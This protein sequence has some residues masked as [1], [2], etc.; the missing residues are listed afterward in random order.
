[1]S[2]TFFEALSA[3]GPHPSLGPDAE[4]YGQF[5]GSWTGEV[6]DYL[7]DGT[8]NVGSVEIHFRWVLEGRRHGNQV[9]QLGT[10]DG[11][12]IRWTFSKSHCRLVPLAGSRARSRRWLLAAGGGV[13]RGAHGVILEFPG[14]ANRR[15][16]SRL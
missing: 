16:G 10:R 7:Q 15:S 13:L 3:P 6:R 4:T 14:R 8:R 1:M 5:I 11:T 9:V 2:N 12:P